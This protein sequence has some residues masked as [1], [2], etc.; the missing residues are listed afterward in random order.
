MTLSIYRY[1]SLKPDIKGFNIFQSFPQAVRPPY[2]HYG[3]K[4]FPMWRRRANLNN[5]SVTQN[6]LKS[7]KYERHDISLEDVISWKSYE[8]KRRFTKPPAKG[9]I[10]IQRLSYAKFLTIFSEIVLHFIV[11]NLSSFHRPLTINPHPP[12]TQVSTPSRQ[13]Q[14]SLL[15][16]VLSPIAASPLRGNADTEAQMETEE[17]LKDIDLSTEISAT[18]TRYHSSSRGHP[19]T[20]RPSY[21][22]TEISHTNTNHHSSSRGHRT[23]RRPHSETFS[24]L[25]QQG[26]RHCWR[27]N[28]HTCNFNW[29]ILIFI[30]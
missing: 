13:S 19:T 21:L 11:R 17:S 15:P 22:S 18:N 3:G 6:I 12:S 1:I 28:C 4:G 25:R 20:R 30:I 2:V 5:L 27:Y 26:L 14:P 7:L 16:A 29:F 23:T 24:G 10:K 8:G 9:C